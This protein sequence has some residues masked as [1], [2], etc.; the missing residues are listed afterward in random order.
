[1]MDERAVRDAMTCLHASDDLY[2][3]VMAEVSGAGGAGRAPRR[4]GRAVPLGLAIALALGAALATSGVAYAALSG[5]FAAQVWGDH[6]LGETVA[7]S[8]G[9]EGAPAT[10]TQSFGGVDPET[11]PATVTDCVRAVDVSAEGNG[12]TLAI[13]EMVIDENGGGA[14]TFTL[15][16]PAGVVLREV[17]ETGQL[18]CDGTDERSIDAIQMR[19]GAD[20]VTFDY[21]TVFDRASRTDTSID[22][23]LYFTAFGTAADLSGQLIWTLN[24]HE[25]DA[26]GGD[27]EHPADI[28]NHE[29]TTQPASVGPVIEAVAARDG[30][31]AEAWLSPLTLRFQIPGAGDSGDKEFVPSYVAFTMADGSERVVWDG[32]AGIMNHYHANLSEDGSI[33]Y[34]LSQYL[35][36]EEVQSLTVR[37]RMGV[38]ESQAFVLTVQP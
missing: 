37:G 32:S 4:R 19:D 34:A 25:G 13:H 3:R 33:T 36:V 12:Y 7:W 20:R 11:L 1:M 28:V 2:E 22:G 35:P 24:W 16:N 6:G 29:A 21:R 14:V 5:V 38:G 23:V 9:A 31:G 10:W 18:M 17:P 15:S 30:S 27:K 8:S 26:E